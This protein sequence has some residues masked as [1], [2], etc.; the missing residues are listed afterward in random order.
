MIVIIRRQSS[1]HH[2]PQWSLSNLR[3]EDALDRRLVVSPDT[4]KQSIVSS[5]HV[6]HGVDPAVP[7]VTVESSP[8]V[9]RLVKDVNPEV[10]SVVRVVHSGRGDGGIGVEACGAEAGQVSMPVT[11]RVIMPSTNG[12]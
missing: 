12:V 4:A 10:P 8:A 9:P 7:S 3:V 1:L 5:V 2:P 11:P 6:Q